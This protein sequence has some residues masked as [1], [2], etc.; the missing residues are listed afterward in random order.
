MNSGG[1]DDNA[2]RLVVLSFVVLCCFIATLVL[3]LVEFPV[4]SWVVL[5]VC[6]CVD[7]YLGFDVGLACTQV[8]CFDSHVLLGC[9]ARVLDLC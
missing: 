5:W 9:F 1:N 2:Y 8:V 3:R 4:C 7:F 6:L